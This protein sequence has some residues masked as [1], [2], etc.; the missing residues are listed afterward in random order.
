M[1][2]RMGK[3]LG[4]L[5]LFLTLCIGF[6]PAAGAETNLPTGA[7][8]SDWAKTEVS[9]AYDTGLIPNQ[10]E[11]GTDYQKAVTRKQ[12]A[13][14][15]VE[16]VLV[17]Q[18][19]T[20]E[21]LMVE[22][23]MLP[24]LLEDAAETPAEALETSDDLEDT[25][26]TAED[27]VEEEISVPPETVPVMPVFTPMFSDCDDVYVELAARLG[28]VK[29]NGSAFR[30]N[31]T[32]QRCEAAL[33]LQ[34]SMETL[35]YAA[36]N[37]KPKVFEDAYT[38][39]K[40]AREGVK[41]IS[42]RTTEEGKAVMGGLY[43]NFMPSKTYSIEQAIVTVLR[44]LE[45]CAV[46]QTYDDWK[47][48][49]G[50]DTVR[51]T[52]S[53]GG[54]C[55][56]GRTRGAS[57]SGSFD[58]MYDKQGAAYFFSN[59]KEFFTDDLTMVNFEGAL[60]T[61]DVPRENKQFIF[62]GRAEYGKILQAGSVDVVTVANNH[63]KDYGERGLADTKKNLAP[64]V[65]VSGF[66]DLPILE[67]KGVKVGFASALG[68]SF[69]A[70]Q[71]KFITDSIKNLRSRGAEVI[72]FNYHWGVEKAYQSNATQKAIGRYC[73]DQGADLVIGH[74]PHVVQE[75]ETYKGKQIVYSLGNL[76]FGGN[77]NPSDKNCLIFQQ[78]FTLNLDSRKITAESHAAIPYKISSVS[79]RN[80]YC[81]TPA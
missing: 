41:Y 20:A 32:L 25:S 30:P 55:T 31:G 80:D 21:D 70:S 66:G 15:S 16:L 43:G 23:G 40:W 36:P 65:A 39:P 42:G 35:G 27:F 13:R 57:Y 10:M 48:A 77:R 17:Q 22:F 45:S 73:I 33:M 6:S 74:H 81:P 3:G 64:Y 28:I 60:T 2:E 61:Y 59:V 68:W 5:G 34:R 52:M 1:R 63:A 18:G 67:V 37:A 53:F 38:I 56:F 24:P 51:I 54:D 71:K 19:R 46:T 47:T 69:D 58:E 7:A 11:W 79:N 62:K 76:C 44:C 14:L 4:V 9:A 78:T 12:F 50:Y 49:A 29:G 75:V 8:M 26:D 72:V